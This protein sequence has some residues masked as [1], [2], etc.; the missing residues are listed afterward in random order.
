MLKNRFVLLNIAVLI[1]E[2]MKRIDLKIA[3]FLFVVA[4]IPKPDGNSSKVTEDEVPTE[5]VV[6]L[7]GNFGDKITADGAINTLDLLA[8]LEGTDSIA[9]KVEGEILATCA[10]KGCWMNVTLKEKEHMRVSFKDYGF[11]VPTEGVE[12]K[13]VIVEG[14]AKKVTTDVETLQH[15]AKD[16]GKSQEEIEAITEPQEEIAFVAS[17]VIIK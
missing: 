6:Q 9:A 7:T 3:V 2:V 15:F 10:I 11:F 1:I 13:K 14:Y 17:G 16:A 8:K 5:K 12:G 4:C